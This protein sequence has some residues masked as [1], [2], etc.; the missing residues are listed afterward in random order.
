MFTSL[1][2]AI[3]ICLNGEP[4]I[5]LNPDSATPRSAKAHPAVVSSKG[6]L[7]DQSYVV[8]RLRH[9][10]GDVT[11]ISVEEYVSLPQDGAIAVRFHSQTAAQAFLAIA[12]I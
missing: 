2:V 9:S 6:L 1:P 11:C 7:D 12:K 10:V 5:T 3:Q 8:R 4:I